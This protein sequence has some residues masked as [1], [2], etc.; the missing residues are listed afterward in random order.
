MVLTP[1][2]RRRYEEKLAVLRAVFISRCH[3][4]VAA[5]GSTYYRAVLGIVSSWASRD[6]WLKLCFVDKEGKV[7]RSARKRSTW[8]DSK[9]ARLSM[10]YCNSRSM[11]SKPQTVITRHR[12]PRFAISPRRRKRPGIAIIRM[13]SHAV[14]ELVEKGI[15]SAVDLV[16]STS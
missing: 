8:Y 10:Y 1:R 6:H 3:G 9:D 12:G 7:G 16:G 15:E 2:V 13:R 14:S 4:R 5:T 11:L